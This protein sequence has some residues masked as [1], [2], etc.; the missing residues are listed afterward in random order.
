MSMAKTQR[1]PGM[2]TLATAQQLVKELHQ[3][4]WDLHYHILIGGGVARE[5][6]SDKDLDLWFIPLN[7]FESEP[8]SITQFLYS[9]FGHL[10]ALRDHPD[11]TG[12]SPWHLQEMLY[13]DY[14]G[15]RI[16]LFIQ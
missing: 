1:V 6:H 11:Y 8:R 3:P 14:C 12:G 16:D 9:I 2:W 5:G 7:G 10:S 15:K 13:V 4:I